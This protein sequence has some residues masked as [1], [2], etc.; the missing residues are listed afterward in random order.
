MFDLAYI[1]E[2]G[3]R[4]KT[5]MTAKNKKGQHFNPATGAETLD[6]LG[7]LGLGLGPK[8]AE[9]ILR[10]NGKELS[11]IKKYSFE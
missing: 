9:E 4:R 1:Y 8:K 10:N 2:V 3:V 7:S 6:G 11:P 5:V